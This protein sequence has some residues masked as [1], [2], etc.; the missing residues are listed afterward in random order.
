MS[1]IPSLLKL[2]A[3]SPVEGLLVHMQIVTKSLVCVTSFFDQ[4]LLKDW[5]KALKIKQEI[6]LI[7]HDADEVKYK[8]RQRL[9]ERLYLSVPR[10]SVL[11]LLQKQDKIANR[12]KD[13]TGIMYGRR[14]SFPL[15]LGDSFKELLSVMPELS[16]QLVV[17]IEDLVQAKESMASNELLEKLHATID[18]IELIEHKTDGCLRAL[19][20]YLFDIE[21]NINA[22]SS[23]IDIVFIYQLARDTASITDQAQSIAHY[24]NI[25]LME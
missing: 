3:R 23:A 10:Q 16:K 24:V 7:E 9:H 13:V 8:M 2:I 19:N 4:V 22:C 11:V 5:D 6:E 21:Q 12:I 20:S 18:Q 14:M 15:L 25:L 17:L 1:Q